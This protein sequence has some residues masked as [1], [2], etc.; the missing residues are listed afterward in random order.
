MFPN[1]HCLSKEKKIYR[2]Q[3]NSKLSTYKKDLLIQACS[4]QTNDH[5]TSYIHYTSNI[6][7]HGNNKNVYTKQCSKKRQL[8][9]I[10]DTK[11]LTNECFF[12]YRADIIG[13]SKYS[14]GERLNFYW[15]EK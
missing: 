13:L 14:E 7:H 4:T 12:W 6:K 2:W 3:I 10:V 5:N 15:F 8:H 1:P 11:L 9:K